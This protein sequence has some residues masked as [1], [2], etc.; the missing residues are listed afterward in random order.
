M[1]VSKCKGLHIICSSFYICI[2]KL[3]FLMYV[4]S[5]LLQLNNTGCRNKI[6]CSIFILLVATRKKYVCMYVCNV[7]N[8]CNVL[9]ICTLHTYDNV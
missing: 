8:V 4:L 6:D 5:T 2:N 3:P 9:Y 1:I 7:C